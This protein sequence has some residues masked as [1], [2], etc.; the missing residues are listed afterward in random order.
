MRAA[1]CCQLQS[2][3]R[4]I[5]HCRCAKQCPAASWETVLNVTATTDR[6]CN[7][8]IT[9]LTAVFSL[10]F[11][12]N[13]AT[14]AQQLALDSALRT[15]IR[16]VTSAIVETAVLCVIY[17]PGSVV[18]V[19]QLLTSDRTAIQALRYFSTYCALVSVC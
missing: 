17:S 16:N 8:Q 13:A 3:E 1:E 9:N 5:N 6:V 14:V 19:M 11:A 7:S 12:A 10:S 2:I 4:H 15:S 18:A